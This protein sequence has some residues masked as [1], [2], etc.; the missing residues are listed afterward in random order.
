MNRG[1]DVGQ[2]F[3]SALGGVSRFPQR[4]SATEP[5]NVERTGGGEGFELCAFQSGPSNE[6][7]QVTKI[8]VRVAFG[9]DC[10]RH[11]SPDSAHVR[12]PHPYREVSVSSVCRGHIGG[13]LV[14]RRHGLVVVQKARVDSGRALIDSRR[15]ESR[16]H[17]RPSDAGDSDVDPVSFGVGGQCRPGIETHRL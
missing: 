17:P 12:E 10:S 2:I 9:N 4:L 14:E 15:L 8:A 3:G 7:V 5:Q 6:V 1:R 11:F 16:F 13:V